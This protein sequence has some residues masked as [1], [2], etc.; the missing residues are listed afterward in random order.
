MPASLGVA[1][2]L[3]FGGALPVDQPLEFLSETLRAQKMV[4]ETAGLRGTRSRPASRTRAGTYRVSGT[5]RCAPAPGELAALLPYVLGG[6]PQADTPPGFTTFPLAET[7]PGELYIAVDRVAAVFT[8][9]RCRIVRATFRAA[10]GSLLGLELEIEG[11]SES[12]AAAGSF[13]PLSPTVQPPFAFLDA[14]LLLQGAPRAIKQ[15]EVTV[16]NLADRERFLNEPTRAEIPVLD[17]LVTLRALLPYTAAEAG[18]YDPPLSGGPAELAF[19]NGAY[20]LRLVFPGAVQFPAQSPVVNGRGEILLELAG[21]ARAA[22]GEPEL[23]IV[24]ASTG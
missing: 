22:L 1:A 23:R 17:R 13:P 11:R 21:V 14:V 9:D 18:L 12:V 8:Y 19:T 10:E 16:E 20:A 2:R 24:L 15:V 4:L 7:L 3:G 5:I 6:D